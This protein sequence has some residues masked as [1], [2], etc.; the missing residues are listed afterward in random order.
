ML[1]FEAVF[2]SVNK[3][4]LV[5]VHWVLDQYIL[6]QQQKVFTQ[7]CICMRK[8]IVFTSTRSFALSIVRYFEKL[9]MHACRG[10]GKKCLYTRAPHEFNHW[11]TFSKKFH[12]SIF[13]HTV[14]TKL[15]LFPIR[16]VT[17]HTYR[18]DVCYLRR[19]YVRGNTSE[20]REWCHE[21]KL[22][23]CVNPNSSF[24]L[25]G[26]ES[27]APTLL[28]SPTKMHRQIR[29]FRRH[30][31][32]R[33]SRITSGSCDTLVYCHFHQRLLS[34][35]ILRYIIKTAIKITIQNTIKSHI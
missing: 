18:V 9:C 6:V 26:E 16:S 29:A 20:L 21:T 10:D 2:F 1:E 12:H 19:T 22:F 27:V 4:R 28:S 34:S 23:A 14:K 7:K 15:W 30:R 5:K 33:V 17:S 31:Q 24:S 3:W 35:H 13:I 8:K 25:Q 32:T 11:F